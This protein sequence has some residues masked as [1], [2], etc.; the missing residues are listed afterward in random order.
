MIG[1]GAMV[2]AV[3]IAG[4]SA[5]R[6]EAMGFGD[7]TF[8]MMVG[9][10]LGW[11]AGI[12]VFFL[13]PFAG[14]IVGLVQLVLRRDDVI[15]FVP[16]LALAA[17]AV[18]VRWA[19]FWNAAPLGLQNTFG[20]PWLIPAVLAI[21]VVMLWAALVLWRNIKEAIFGASDE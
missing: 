4:T 5:L 15:P 9:A 21:C 11:Q 16:Y 1:A 13:A 2:W 14:L 18:L 8:M 12:I 6:R 3:R 19:D 10:Y 17:L 20:V 7:V